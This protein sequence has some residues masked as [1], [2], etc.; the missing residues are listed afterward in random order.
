[1]KVVELIVNSTT[2]LCLGADHE[3]S[4]LTSVVSVGAGS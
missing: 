1:M 4:L 3:I 2:E